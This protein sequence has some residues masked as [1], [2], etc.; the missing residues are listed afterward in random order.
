M[1]VPITEVGVHTHNP[2]KREA[3]CPS[4]TT[5]Q[6]LVSSQTGGTDYARPIDDLDRIFDRILVALN[7]ALGADGR[8]PP[9]GQQ[10]DRWPR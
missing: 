3:P 2:R 6:A 7:A 5:Y 4:L 10:K 9:S 1:E 8:A